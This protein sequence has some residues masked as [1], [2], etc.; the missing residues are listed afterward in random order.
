MENQMGVFAG[1]TVS[2]QYLDC[3]PTYSGLT[4]FFSEYVN[5]VFS[6]KIKYLFFL[7]ANIPETMANI[8]KNQLVNV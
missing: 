7:F 2:E 3:A 1:F 4:F 8:K 6:E 5:K